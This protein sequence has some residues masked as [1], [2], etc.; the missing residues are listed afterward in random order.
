MIAIHSGNAYESKQWLVSFARYRKASPVCCVGGTI[1][2]P[3]IHYALWLVNSTD[4]ASVVLFA[5]RTL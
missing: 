1:C 3:R 4:A 2:V 5:R